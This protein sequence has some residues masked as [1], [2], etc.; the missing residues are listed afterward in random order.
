MKK[1]ALFFTLPLLVSFSF[2]TPSV[3]KIDFSIDD[4][5]QSSLKT[6][7][8]L[9]SNLDKKELKSE[10]NLTKIDTNETLVLPKKIFIE[11]GAI[12]NEKYI[13][14]K[15]YKSAKNIA[16]DID[17]KL[18]QKINLSKDFNLTNEKFKDKSDEILSYE[19]T[20]FNIEKNYSKLWAKAS[21]KYELKDI[22][23]KII[24]TN[25][26]SKTYKSPF[27]TSSLTYDDM[28]E[29]LSSALFSELAESNNAKHDENLVNDEVVKQTPSGGVVLPF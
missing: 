25:T 19:I 24:K 3:T 15:S 13:V 17:K 21:L 22:K 29:K 11:D 7:L 6:D 28:I 9:T 8:N 12:I 2:C 14:D 16:K 1:I 23:G 26:I 18:K 27:S 4:V 10:Q 20:K 5:N